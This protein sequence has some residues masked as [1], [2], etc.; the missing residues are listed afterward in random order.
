VLRALESLR[1]PW[2]ANVMQTLHALGSQ[3][4]LRALTWGTVAA[5]IV[6]KRW[7]HLFVF[8]GARVVGHALAANAAL[9]L[10][11]PRPVGIDV[12]GIWDGFSHP[13]GAVSALA[14]TLVGITYSDVSAGQARNRAKWGTG[15]LLGCLGLARMYLGV[16]HPTDILA[17]VIGGVTVPLVAFRL[18]TPNDVFPSITGAPAPPILRLTSGEPT[19]SEPHSR[20]NSG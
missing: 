9:L 14:T 4:T 18:I 19:R 17:G 15:A 11:R 13:S 10:A 5:L 6:F 3:W 1:T 16:D 2:L 8:L 7:R 12:I 20:S